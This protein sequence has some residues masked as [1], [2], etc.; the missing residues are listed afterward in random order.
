MLRFL[1]AP[2]L[3]VS[4]P[5]ASQQAETPCRSHDSICEN[6]VAAIEHFVKSK[7]LAEVTSVGPGPVSADKVPLYNGKRFVFS[8]ILAQSDE[9]THLAN[10][11]CYLGADERT[12][13]W[14]AVRL[15]QVGASAN[16]DLPLSKESPSREAF[17]AL[18]DEQYNS[19]GP[20]RAAMFGL[21]VDDLQDFNTLQ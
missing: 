4:P 19:L 9:G 20:S 17:R 8:N 7:T 18:S 1:L 3:L 11:E 16:V 12:I 15:R 5:V 14:L 10:A 21:G 13:E 6:C 2:L